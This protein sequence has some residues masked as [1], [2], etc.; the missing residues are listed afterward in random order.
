[1][2]QI[3][4]VSRRQFLKSTGVSAALV[5]GTQTFGVRYQFTSK[6]RL[7]ETAEAIHAM[8]SDILKCYLGRD[9][10]KQYAMPQNSDIN[11]L[12]VRTTDPG[13]LA[14]S[15]EIRLHSRVGFAASCTR[16]VTRWRR[17]AS[18]GR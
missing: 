14:T 4:Q 16:S 13:L 1:M 12:T 18:G 5:L 8:G 3:T 15:S 10:T 6:T 7:V 11:S 17:P 9:Y 2:A